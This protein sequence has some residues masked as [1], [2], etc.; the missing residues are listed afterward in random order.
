MIGTCRLCGNERE[1]LTSH[2]MPSFIF[3]RMKKTSATGHIRFSQNMNKREQ[4]GLK[5]PWFCFDCEQLFS[6]YEKYFSEKILQPIHQQQKE[7]TYNNTLSKFAASVA[8]RVLMYFIEIND[9]EHI[10]PK[11]REAAEKSW[12]DYL[13]NQNKHPDSHE[14]HFYNLIGQI[15]ADADTP[16]NIF[17][18]LS[19]ATDLSVF[20]TQ[21]ASFVYI[22]SL[23]FLII[24]YIRLPQSSRALRKSRI[25]ISRVQIT[26]GLNELPE[27]IWK[28]IK[29]RAR[30]SQNH[31]NAL[32]ESEQLKIDKAYRTNLERASKSETIKALTKDAQAFG[33]RSIFNNGE[34]E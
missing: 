29:E 31:Q 26:Q 27:F 25:C 14:L 34:E 15:P 23:N 16:N 19:R 5:F 13:L 18:Y 32:S 30:K 28:I 6:K 4:D 21:D 17:R 7:I 2:I 1:L 22:K 9:I 24:G 8:W 12:H 20:K 3:K 33:V 11:D 10:N